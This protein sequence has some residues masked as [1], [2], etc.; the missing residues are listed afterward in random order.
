MLIY[1]IFKLYKLLVFSANDVIPDL[2]LD[3]PDYHATWISI[4][5]GM[6]IFLDMSAIAKLFLIL[7]T[8]NMIR[9]ACAFRRRKT[10]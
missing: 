7:T 5:R 4:C 6:S 9:I 3:L 2:D 10:L 8:Y 1:Y